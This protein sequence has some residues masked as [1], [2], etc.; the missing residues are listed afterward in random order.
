MKTAAIIGSHPD[1]RGL[2]DFER[3]DCDVWCFNE[4]VSS[5]EIP[6]ASAVFQ[7]HLPTVWR[8]LSKHYD[9]LRT[10]TKAE[11][12]MQQV[13]ADVPK[14]TRY[15]IEEV[16]KLGYRYLT[17]SVAY[18]IALAI[19]RGYERIELYGIEMETNTEYGY[20]RQGLA[21]WVGMA[22]GL[23]IDVVHVSEKFWRAP[24][25]GYEDNIRVPL[26]YYEKRIAELQEKYEEQKEQSEK[27]I[28]D[29]NAVVKRFVKD[30][31][32]DQGTFFDETITM[33]GQAAINLGILDGAIQTNQQYYEEH[34]A[35]LAKTGDY[36]THRQGIESRLYTA[37]TEQEKQLRGVH[38]KADRMEKARKGLLTRANQAERI[39]RAEVFTRRF[40]DYILACKLTGIAGG[41]MHES[42]VLIA[43]VDHASG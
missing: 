13:Y 35:A 41:V 43:Q 11:V 1:T 23:G 10:Q 7:L 38:V 22:A 37:V 27:L 12:I 15:P 9:W 40:T 28:F 39:K 5:G 26:E 24:L 29:V 6:W 30:F 20:Q 31:K 3:T 18:A 17:S 14:A 16:E 4:T 2:F 19:V 34:K 42:K 33:A 36:L 21:Y 8:A 32:A 25:Y